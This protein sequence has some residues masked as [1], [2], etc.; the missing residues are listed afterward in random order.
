[1]I[2]LLTLNLLMAKMI[3]QLPQQCTG[4]LDKPHIK[5]FVRLMCLI[6]GARAKD[7]CRAQ[8]LNERRYTAVV[9]FLNTG[10][11]Q[12]LNHCHHGVIGQA[13]VAWN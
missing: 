2:P 9:N 5:I 11:Q 4:W 8:L 3:Y 12:L 7:Q 6:D 10:A 1:M 13:F